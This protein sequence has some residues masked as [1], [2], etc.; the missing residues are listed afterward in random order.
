MNDRFK[1]SAKNELRCRGC[2]KRP[3]PRRARL[4]KRARSKQRR[5]EADPWLEAIKHVLCV[6]AGVAP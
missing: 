6:L 1:G 3:G 2:N 4:M 5:R